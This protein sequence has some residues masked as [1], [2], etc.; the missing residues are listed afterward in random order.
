MCF[1]RVQ[2]TGKSRVEVEAEG[3]SGKVDIIGLA[4]KLIQQAKDKGVAL[5]LRI[6]FLATY[7]F[8]PN[9]VRSFKAWS[10]CFHAITAARRNSRMSRPSS[11]RTKTSQTSTW[12]LTLDPRLK[13]VRHQQNTFQHLLD[14]AS[15]FSFRHLCLQ[16]TSS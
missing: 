4:T 5:L 13:P 8:L 6:L 14:I 12:H 1:H 2:K 9:V 15:F 7:S 10:L 3:K 11:P 16:H